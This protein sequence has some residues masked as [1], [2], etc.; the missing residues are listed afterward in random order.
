MEGFGS[1]K[2]SSDVAATHHVVIGTAGHIDHGKTALVEALTGVNA[3]RLKEEKARGITIDLGFVFMGDQITIIDVPG[4]E[5]FIKNMVA[6]VSAIDLVLL[7]VAADDGVM[8]QTR[9]HLDILRLLQVKRGIVALTKSDLV[10]EEWLEL[11]REEISDLVEDTFLKGAPVIAVSSVTGEGIEELS[12][13]I[14]EAVRRA[15]GKV[16]REI[17]RMPV[18]RSFSMRGF[19]TVVTG[20]VLSG[21][22]TV[23]DRVELLPAAKELRIRGIQQHGRDASDVRVGDRAAINLVG[24]EREGV[25]RGDLLAAPGYFRPSFMMDA[26][27][28]LL[29]SCPKPL[30]NRTRV[31]LHIGTAEIM[32]RVVLLDKDRL[33]PG[34]SGLVQLRLETPG[35]AT[36]S[37]PFVIRRYSPARTI[38]GGRVLDGVPRK[39]G[40]LEPEVLEMLAALEQEDPA[41]VI[42]ARLRT[43]PDEM[44]SPRGI[45]AE[46][47]LASGMVKEHLDRLEAEGRIRTLLRDDEILVFDR[48]HWDAL[49]G[50]TERTLQ[51]FHES[52]PLRPGLKREELRDILGARVDQ[53]LFDTLL[54]DLR[55]RGRIKMT[56]AL[57]SMASHRIRFSPHQE[58]LSEKLEE[59]LLKEGFSPSGEEELASALGA[60]RDEVRAV[61]DAMRSMGK[62]VRV[63]ES[64]L[65]HARTVEEAKTRLTHYLRERDQVTISEFRDLIGASRK[66][67]LPLMN[68]FDAIRVTER[69]GDVRVLREDAEE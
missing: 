59:T 43:S 51:A 58:A 49:E 53:I 32:A 52:H 36:R 19:G 66:Y 68:Y 25:T 34:E 30:K 55:D 26:R 27:L 10:D 31:R 61:L 11:V 46:T 23:G 29:K 13:A 67:A 63:D 22:V 41:E 37:D 62:L 17:F 14:E 15:E 42:L 3:D 65:F 20:T 1:H 40:R 2:E 56:E 24:V 8:P 45:A 18:D 12:A 6:G 5:R 21:S 38:G 50:R 48:G 69:K 44:K 57:L 60:R 4:H 9:E 35:V 39:H 47:G 16:D 33:G 28:D 64:A 54:A 7:V